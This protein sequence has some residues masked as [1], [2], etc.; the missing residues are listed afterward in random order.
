MKPIPL[1]KGG[2]GRSAKQLTAIPK[3][4]FSFQFRT[5]LAVLVAIAM[6]VNHLITRH[7]G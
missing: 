2:Q 3:L 1:I 5:V 6:A 4:L 7:G